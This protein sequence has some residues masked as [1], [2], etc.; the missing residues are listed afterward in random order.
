MTPDQMNPEICPSS[1]DKDG[2]LDRTNGP[3]WGQHKY[4]DDGICSECGAIQDDEDEL[5]ADFLAGKEA[6][7]Q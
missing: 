1:L 2:N 5:G 6:L 4:D 7:G 3:E